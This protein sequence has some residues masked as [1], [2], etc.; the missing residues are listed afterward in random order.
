MPGVT[1][2][3]F[4]TRP[5]IVGTHG[6]VASTHWLASQSGMAVLE[7]GG[8]AF[9]AAVTTG[10]VL[11][12]V[13]PHLN[14]LG[15]DVPVIG[16]LAPSGE[17]FVLAGQGPAPAAA[18]AQ[19]FADLGLDH[20]PG[21]G[22]LAA[23][24]PGAF[25]TW[26]DLL[27]RY[28]TWRVAD[29]LAPAIGYA[30]HGYPLLAQASATI[31]RVADMFSE[32]W[33][34]SAEVYLPGGRVPAPMS[35]FSNPDLARTLERLVHEA[36]A[37]GPDRDA[38]IEAARSA[39]YEGFVADAIAASSS[40]SVVDSTG[41]A[42]RGLL[43]RAD[44]AGWRVREERPATLDFAGRTIAKTGPW[45]Q[46]PVLLQQLALLDGT[47]LADTRPG[48]AEL[49][50]AVVEGAKLAFAD[51]DAWYGDPDHTDVPIDALLS[52][53]YAARRRELIDAD[54]SDELRPG[55][56]DGVEPRLPAR[57][58]AEVERARRAS[59]ST[60]G[61]RHAVA[62][63]G[64]PTF[65]PSDTGTDPAVGRDG[66]VRGDTCHL[67]VVDRHGNVVS[68]TP[69]GGWLQSSPVIGSLGFQ[70]P[71][72]AQM[73]WVEQGLP[74]SLGPGRRPRTT[75]SPTLVLRDGAPEIACGT[76]GGDQQ[77]QWQLPFLLNH[78]VFG[79][80]LQEAIDA[81]TWHTTHLV[82]S[83][84]PR[85][86]ELRGLHAE[87]RLGRDV[88]DDLRRRGHA[89][90]VT[91]PWSLGRL[92]AAAR[93]ADGMLHAAATPRGMQAYAVGR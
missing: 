48:S 2:P 78:L 50:H 17:P 66:T 92:T 38:Q 67:D 13:E 74:G 6:M 63:A 16:C 14:G 62:G 46:G 20:V 58:H 30:R 53:G 32:H 5:E 89:L 27:A 7:Q 61:S 15:G 79:M 24:V 70:L 77:D 71:T 25:G 23:V 54:A 60:S 91:G 11:H 49:V 84:D 35:R 52:P 56:P 59:G 22:L 76:P 86:I 51:R 65:A 34:T 73:F 28:G 8:N 93:G 68:V 3:A 47:D 81:P 64:E 39:F 45:G 40:R 10:M 37:A 85:E 33:P 19:A 69:S 29:V 43:S 42:H 4:T 18:T 57:V 72:R 82:S 9:D 21:T 83:F 41:R 55:S 12:V 44:L 80:G 36:E 1:S 90:T 75:L 88:L 26:M 87:E 31:A